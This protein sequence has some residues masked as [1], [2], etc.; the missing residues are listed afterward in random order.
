MKHRIAALGITGQAFAQKS[1]NQIMK[2]DA[3]ASATTYPVSI[4][5]SGEIAGWYQ[6]ATGVHGFLR[7]ERDEEGSITTFDVPGATHGVP[8][9]TV[10]S[11]ISARGKIIGE[12]FAGDSIHGFLRDR[13][14]TITTV[15]RGPQRC[16]PS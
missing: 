7:D 11:G 9:G 5:A 6:D 3:T 12:Y 2:I 14:G 16:P 15:R 1:K 8:G 13:D 10:P 4:N